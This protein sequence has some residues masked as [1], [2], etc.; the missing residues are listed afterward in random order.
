MQPVLITLSEIYIAVVSPFKRLKLSTLEVFEWLYV[1][2]PAY[3]SSM[4]FE[5]FFFNFTI[6]AF[7]L[8]TASQWDMTSWNIDKKV[9]SYL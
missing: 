4:S 6:H 8:E 7:I 1:S 9:K 2:H 3:L 5:Y